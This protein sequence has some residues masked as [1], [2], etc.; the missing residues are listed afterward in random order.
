MQVAERMGGLPRIGLDIMGDPA[1]GRGSASDRDRCFRLENADSD[2]PP[3][4]DGA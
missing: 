1:D 3:S 2:I 4:A